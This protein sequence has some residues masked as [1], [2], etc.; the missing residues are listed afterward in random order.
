MYQNLMRSAMLLKVKQPFKDWLH[1]IEPE[2]FNDFMDDQLN[3]GEVY[4]LPDYETVKEMQTWL[5]NNYDDIFTEALNDWYVDED[6]WPEN[7][8]FEM[9]NQWF[10]Y[11][12]HTMVLDTVKGTIRKI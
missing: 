7:R 1:S 9:F 5:K 3:E 10:E 8:T 6:V 4:L 12:L 11:S 2:E